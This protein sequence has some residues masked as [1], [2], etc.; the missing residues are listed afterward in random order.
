MAGLSIVALDEQQRPWANELLAAEWGAAD[1]IVTRGRVYDATA[2]PGFVALDQGRPVGLLTYR[3]EGDE[4]EI[5][6][7]NSLA[8]GQGIGTALLAAAQEAARAAGCWRL[9]LI[10]TNDNLAA[11]RFYQ[12]RGF[13]LAA[14]YPNSLEESRRLKPQIPLIGLDGIPLR[15]EIE[16]EMRLI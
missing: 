3:L 7:L 8:E 9:W 1:R 12:R 14:L 4:C 11:L 5:I 10:T 15:D 16:L 13:T 2:L 6:S